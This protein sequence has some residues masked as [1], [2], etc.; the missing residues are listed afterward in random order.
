MAYQ[1]SFEKL[2]VWQTA[3]ILVKDIYQ[4]TENFPEKER[5]GLTNQMIRSAVSVCANLAEGATRSSSKE[6]AHFTSISYGSLIE[7]LS[8]LIVSTDLK[9]MSEETLNE[10]REKIQPL[11]VKINNLRNQQLSLITK[12]KIN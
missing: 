10:F 4:L 1:F 7:L 5:F 2:E 8:H 6:Q 9:F 12:L 3:R 11:S